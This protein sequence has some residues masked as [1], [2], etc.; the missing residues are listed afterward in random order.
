MSDLIPT[1]TAP[2][3]GA[4]TDTRSSTGAGAGAARFDGSA[5][6]HLRLHRLSDAEEKKRNRL[7]AQLRVAQKVN[8]R[9]Q[10]YY[11][12]SKRVRDLGISIPPHLK[13]VEA[14]TAWPEIVVDVIDERSD[15][16]GWTVDVDDPDGEPGAGD[17][18][19]LGEAYDVNHLGIEVSQAVLDSLI[20][21]IGFLSTGTGEDGEPDVLVKAESPSMMTATWSPR[22]RRAVEALRENKASTGRITGWTLFELDSTIT[23]E[24]RDGGGLLVVDRD[25]H[26]MNRI[27]VAVLLNRP[28]SSRTSGRS[29]IT[30]AVRSFTESGMRTLLGMEVSREFY[31][32]PQRFLMGANEDMFLDEKGNLKPAWE[33]LLGRV[34]VAPLNEVD[35]APTAGQF[36]AASPQPFTEVLKSLAQMVSAA[37]GLPATHLGF[38]TDNPSSAD[39]ID[40]ADRRLNS[41]ARRRHSQYDLGLIELG[42]TICLWRDDDLP[43][44]GIIRSLWT[45]PGAPPPAAQADRAVKMITAGALDPTWDFT[46]EQFGLTDDEIRRVK[47]ERLRT[48]GRTSLTEIIDR[49]QAGAG[50]A[51]A[52]G[53]GGEGD[54]SGDG[55]QPPA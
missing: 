15:W 13:D 52:D 41:R 46:L 49:V 3:A 27:P 25:E 17:P 32:A 8:A 6:A 44:A 5:P 53:A 21:G 30:R 4:G 26:E 9:Q 51:P 55:V 34:L 20:N 54:G 29:E 39:A 43:P 42:R 16:R 35:E 23:T 38:A 18:L 10:S 14:V 40:K 47:K 28:R 11:E 37:T 12:G 24:R 48:Q 36:S 45:D 50:G 31:A 22:L 33:V 1:F 2:P 7:V 19:G